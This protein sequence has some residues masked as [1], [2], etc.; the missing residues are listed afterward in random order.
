MHRLSQLMLCIS[1]AWT[2]YLTG[3]ATSFKLNLYQKPFLQLSRRILRPSMAIIDFSPDEKKA[4]VYKCLENVIDPDSGNDI[5][6][7]GIIR[8]VDVNENGDISVGLQT[9]S[10]EEDIRQQCILL[11]A[12]LPWK[13]Q[14]D[15]K[16]ARNQSLSA[17]NT[18]NQ[19]KAL[20]GM[21][22][23]RNIIAVSSCKGGVGKSTVSVN[24][25]YTLAKVGKAKVG[26]LDADIYGPSLPTMTS[27]TTKDVMIVSNQIVPLEYE[28][29]K[30][31]SMGFINKGASIMRGPMV[32]QILNQFV[33]LVDW[34]DLDYLIVDMP[35]GEN[36]IQP[37]I[38]YISPPYM[39]L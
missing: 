30:L 29:V 35:P 2:S 11:L 18:E 36:S 22:R 3:F 19:S 20:G 1:L 6:S 15:V 5:V 37:I 10:F 25:A 16:V 31:M 17:V 12:A 7:S 39:F 33:S 28:G 14:I 23:V 21:S 4:D 13:N 34:G 32:N 24:L 27:P 9:Q 26:I 8:S 38:N